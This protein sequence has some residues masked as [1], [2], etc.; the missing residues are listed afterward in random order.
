[1]NDLETN[2]LEHL[3]GMDAQMVSEVAR[4]VKCSPV[5]ARQ[6]LHRLVDSGDVLMLKTS[7]GAEL[8]EPAH[9]G[10]SPTGGHAA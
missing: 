2:I 4:A 5:D 7:R 1:M 9:G 6:A 3:H 8:F 10:Y